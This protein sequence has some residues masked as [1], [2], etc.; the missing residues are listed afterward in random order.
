[1]RAAGAACVHGQSTAHAPA[2]HSDASAYPVPQRYL[3]MKLTYHEHTP[4][5]YEPVRACSA[6]SA[7]AR[8][9]HTCNYC[10][11]AA[12]AAQAAR[13]GLPLAQR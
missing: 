10:L 7:T 5:S 12:S 3:F 2:T 4:E 11:H 6:C 13:T 1:M 8:I 9:V